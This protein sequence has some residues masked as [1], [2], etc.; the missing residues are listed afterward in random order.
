MLPLRHARRWQAAGILIL[1][2][3]LA[4][5]LSPAPDLGATRMPGDKWLHAITFTFLTVWFAGQY[6]RASYWRLAVGMLAFGGLIELCQQLLDYRSAEARD[7]LADAIGIAAGLVIAL[8]GAGGW[9]M[10]LENWLQV[11]R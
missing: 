7:L 1:L 11:R 2:A 6:A 3:V 5:A 10:R 9:S 4:A 8:A